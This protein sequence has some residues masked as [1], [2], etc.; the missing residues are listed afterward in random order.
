M[1]PG[2]NNI[3]DDAY[4]T[5]TYRRTGPLGVDPTVTSTMQ[6]AECASLTLDSRGRIVTVCVGPLAPTLKLF[7]PKTL[8]ELASYSLPARTPSTDVLSDFSG[9]GYFY[10]DHRD[11]AVVPTAD[12]H[13]LVVRETAGPGFALARS[14]DL[15]G[16]V[17]RQDKIVSAIPD[18]SGL[19][20]F[21]TQHGV[22]GT[23]D[24]RTGKVRSRGLHETIANSFA[25]DDDGGIYVVTA[26][27]LYRLDAAASGRPRVTWRERYPNSG[28]LKPGQVSAGSGT[29]PT[30]MG[31]DWVAITDNADPMHVVVYRRGA[32]V[33][34]E[35]EICRQA[36]F[37]KGASDTENSLIAAGRAIIVTNNYGYEGPVKSGN[38]ALTEPG[39]ERVDVDRDG[40]GCHTVWRNRTE[41]SPSAVPKLSL[42]NGLVYIV[43]KDPAG[44]H[45]VWY[46]AALDER[47]GRTVFKTRY[48]TG[49]GYNPNY[50]PVSLAPDGA[51]YVGVLGG[52]VRI[53]DATRPR[54]P[55]PKP[56]LRLLP[57]PRIGGPDREFVV[58]ARFQD[59][60][61]VA[62]VLLEGGTRVTLRR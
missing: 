36:V 30:V 20:V 3:H 15:S 14:F 34:G 43:A 19:I 7:D 11:R 41:R 18:W 50:A 47:T 25:V 17:G 29:T 40:R 59:H 55:A 6:V 39:I 22:V 35:R 24:P 8:D 51:A 56:R 33:R 13:L 57:G 32:G 60:G 26:T 53:A 16:A 10:L 5:D 12:R 27:A 2:D 37:R 42:A 44:P 48:G 28:I 21:V 49:L 62:R 31:R 54:V 1:A 45:D 38:G 61:R 4:M 58:R 9:G 52:L 23:V 46:L